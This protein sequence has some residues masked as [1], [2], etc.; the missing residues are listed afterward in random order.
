M[1]MMPLTIHLVLH[2]VFKNNQSILPYSQERVN[3]KN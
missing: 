2:N 1:Q 3:S